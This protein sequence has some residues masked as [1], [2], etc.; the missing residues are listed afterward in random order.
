ML[1][2]I[3]INV[4]KSNVT[5]KDLMGGHSSM[6][7]NGLYVKT[8]SKDEH[9]F[10]AQKAKELARRKCNDPESIEDAI[11]CDQSAHWR[12][13][14][15]DEL[16]SMSKNDVWELVELPKGAKPVG[17][18]WVYKTK[19]DPIGNV[20]RHKAHLVTKWYTQKEGIDY[21]ET[22]SPV[23]RKDSPRIVMALVTHFDLK[24]HQISVRIPQDEWE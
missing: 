11:T 18:K 22:F 10:E 3:E 14:M 21:K 15:E 7:A 8:D 6:S 13:A 12:E 20:E 23:S 4:K 16:N 9:G 1:Y 24:L 2:S 5:E 17:C 19:L